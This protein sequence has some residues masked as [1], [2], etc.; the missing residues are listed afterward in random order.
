[1]WMSPTTLFLTNCW[2]ISK[3]LVG[4]CSAGLSSEGN[5]SKYC[6][7]VLIEGCPVKSFDLSW[8]LP[9]RWLRMREPLFCS[10]NLFILILFCVIFSRSI[11]TIRLKVVFWD[12]VSYITIFFECYCGLMAT[13]IIFSISILIRLLHHVI[14]VSP[15]C[16]NVSPMSIC[17]LITIYIH[18]NI[19]FSIELKRLMKITLCANWIEVK[20]LE[21]SFMG[22]TFTN[23]FRHN[24]CFLE[25]SATRT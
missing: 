18:Q 24:H 12:S 13:L 11:W 9:I 16:L 3:H 20:L 22:F 21:R 19:L 7:V 25:P 14:N 15:M 10:T 17:S 6:L 1:M 23:I 4:L 5:D 2:M 8:S